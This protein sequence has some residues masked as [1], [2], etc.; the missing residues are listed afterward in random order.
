[1]HPFCLRAAPLVAITVFFWSAPAFTRP[2]AALHPVADK[3]E[4]ELPGGARLLLDPRPDTK[5]GELVVALRAGWLERD[6]DHGRAAR[7]LAPCTA[8]LDPNAF[9][10]EAA[11]R[12]A[13]LSFEVGG[14]LAVLRAGGNPDALLWIIDG[15]TAWL[16]GAPYTAPVNVPPVPALG[17]IDGLRQSWGPALWAGNT[18]LAHPAPHGSVSVEQ[19]VAQH[20]RRLGPDA[21]VIGL[22]GPFP[23]QPTADRITAGLARAPAAKVPWEFAGDMWRGIEGHELWLQ[24]AD[25]ETGGKE[26]AQVALLWPGPSAED[27][28]E[29]AASLWRYAV[30]G[31]RLEKLARQYGGRTLIDRG[32]DARAPRTQPFEFAM[33]VPVARAADAAAAMLFAVG[34]ALGEGAPTEEEIEF[35]RAQARQMTQMVARL[36]D[37]GLDLAVR[38]AALG[39]AT[40]RFERRLAAIAAVDAAAALFAAKE[41]VTPDRARIVV[42]GAGKKLAHAF[43]A[44]PLSGE[45]VQR[46]LGAP[47]SSEDGA[48]AADALLERVG[49]RAA[50][51]ALRHLRTD[52]RLV[53]ENNG[54][55]TVVETTQ[56]RAFDRFVLRVDMHAG[57]R[58]FATV[59]G[60]GPAMLGAWGWRDVP[61]AIEVLEEAALRPLVEGERRSLP[62]ILARLARGELGTHLNVAGHLVLADSHGPIA[63]VERDLE[64]WPAQIL[65]LEGE[66]ARSA[67]YGDWAQ[68]AGL[69]FAARY[70]VHGDS[71][72]QYEVTRFTPEPEGEMDLFAPP[73]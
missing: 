23:A 6:P 62:R 56:W 34:D 41:I 27:P 71:D 5:Q 12:G 49:G 45:P 21:L 46:W 22:R 10:A 13:P 42:R 55:R 69:F 20:R 43:T 35:F 64:G 37:G 57:E 28:R 26:R 14:D 16:F 73:Y 52:T 68:I 48:T 47:P 9:A 11:R 17:G 54:R 1:M 3:W 72:R 65:W 19:Q 2:S 30:A 15:V 7:A 66:N 44:V 60:A 70:T 63:R 39:Y 58:R 4:V 29:P 25:G 18:P 32:S 8:D 33:E 31:P 53:L 67:T 51:A 24:D 59:I 36:P 38:H 50:W 61:D 40:D